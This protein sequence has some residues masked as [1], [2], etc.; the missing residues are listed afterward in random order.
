MDSQLLEDKK[1]SG[2]S[3]EDTRKAEKDE[4]EEQNDPGSEKG[5]DSEEEEEDEDDDSHLNTITERS[6]EESCT[7]ANQS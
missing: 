3:S 1:G 6:Y 2:V 5:G 4:I 7:E